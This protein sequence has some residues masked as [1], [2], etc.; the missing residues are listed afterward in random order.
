MKTK[1]IHPVAIVLFLLSIISCVAAFFSDESARWLF[2]HAS[3]PVLWILFGSAIYFSLDIL[4]DWFKNHFKTSWKTLL[5][6]AVGVL[7][8][9]SQV[10]A[11]LKTNS[12]E[13]N[14]L[15]VAHS[16]TLLQQPYNITE[17][18]VYFDI[19]YPMN[20]EIPTR[21]L[22]FPF[23][24]HLSELIFGVGMYAAIIVNILAMIVFGWVFYF[25]QKSTSVFQR[26]LTLTL[27][28]S[29]PLILM[30]TKCAGFDVFSATLLFLTLVFA[31]NYSE[32]RDEK[33][34]TLFWVTTLIFSQVRYE[35]PLLAGITLL[36]LLA[37]TRNFR[38]ILK[39][40]WVALFSAGVAMA[41]WQRLLTQGH[42]ENPEGVAPFG[43]DHLISH[44]SDMITHLTQFGLAY[45]PFLMCTGIL[46]VIWFAI[47][48]DFKTLLWTVP[49]C[50]Q[51]ALGLSHHAG[52]Y[53][54][55]AQVR[56][57]IPFAI[58]CSIL[59]A[60]FL[61]DLKFLDL[62][63]K[64]LIASLMLVFSVSVAS[65]P[66]FLNSLILNRD[67]HYLM[68]LIKNYNQNRTLVVYGR[69]VQF[70]A[71][72]YG[73]ITPER[74]YRERDELTLNLRR[75][76]FDHILLFDSVNYGEEG[77]Q[78]GFDRNQLKQVAMFQQDG[79]THMYIWEL[80]P[81]STAAK[82]VSPK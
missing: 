1:N 75:G 41:L 68:E 50:A 13:A 27:I 36:I 37:T 42:F 60:K 5:L 52:V 22:M 2:V 49:V 70:T 44:G 66:E 3:Y 23:F 43:I 71:L 17:A 57:F 51:I 55:P 39:P 28:L 33:D 80:L 59:S 45:N 10:P 77:R 78:F 61:F 67:I 74:A 30:F 81:E 20:L 54:H 14:L 6:I 73:A 15:S 16:L 62:R 34:L 4:R 7:L 18:K 72:G 63:V 9:L 53:Q 35:N 65:N 56:F 48:G 38:A 69:P 79:G 31:K 29:Q 25:S 32:S 11:V 64:G 12:D 47:K 24:V 21:P 58:L 40:H 8:C 82:P 19:F 46:A 76:L 26:G